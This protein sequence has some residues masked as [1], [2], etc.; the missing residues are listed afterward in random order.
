MYQMVN[1]IVFPEPENGPFLNSALSL[2]PFHLDFLCLTPPRHRGTE[3]EH[4]CFIT[5]LPCPPFLQIR[6]LN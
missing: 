4:F 2:K 5:T 1:S 6:I 3:V